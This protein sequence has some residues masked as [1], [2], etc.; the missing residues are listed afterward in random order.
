M[1]KKSITKEAF[2]T[3]DIC[4]LTGFVNYKLYLRQNKSVTLFMFF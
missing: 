2:Y 4:F 1:I 3:V